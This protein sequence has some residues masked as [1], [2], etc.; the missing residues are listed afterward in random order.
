MTS[1]DPREID[2][3]V[4]WRNWGYVGQTKFLTTT[5]SRADLFRAV[6]LEVE[7]T[8]TEPSEISAQSRFTKQQLARIALKLGL[9]R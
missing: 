6:A 1:D 9:Y 2:L 3:P 7:P 4:R 8:S 5:L